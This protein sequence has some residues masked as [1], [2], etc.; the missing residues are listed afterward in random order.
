MQEKDHFGLS[1]GINIGVCLR[2][3]MYSP[4]KRFISSGSS[5]SRRYAAAKLFRAKT[6]QSHSFVEFKF[7]P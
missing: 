7:F 6:G 2:F 4:P 1:P 3:S 5:I